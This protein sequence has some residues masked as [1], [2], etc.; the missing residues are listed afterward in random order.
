MSATGQDPEPRIARQRL[1]FA[2]WPDDPVRRGLAALAREFVQGQGRLVPPRNL[3]LTLYFLGPL[4]D[5]QRVDA[6]AAAEG[7][8]CPPFTLSLDRLGCWRRARVAWSASSV[9]P[10]ALGAL[11]GAL[12]D[13]LAARGFEL[14]S[15][16]FQVHVTLARKVPRGIPSREHDALEW[17]VSSFHLVESRTYSEGAEYHV[18]RG[19]PLTAGDAVSG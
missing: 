8:A 18:L 2:L 11:A 13:G 12:R 19:W 9:V 17:P 4:T 3:H 5:A 14:E 15:R 16:P 1:F 7:I 6:E 10:P